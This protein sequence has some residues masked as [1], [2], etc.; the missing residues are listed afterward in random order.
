MWI[1]T[2]GIRSRPRITIGPV[3]SSRSLLIMLHKQFGLPKN[4]GE[5][6]M[7]GAWGLGGCSGSPVEV[8]VTWTGFSNTAAATTA[9]HTSPTSHTRL[10]TPMTST[11]SKINFSYVALGLDATVGVTAESFTRV[12]CVVPRDASRTLLLGTPTDPRHGHCVGNRR[13]R[14]QSSSGTRVG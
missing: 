8:R 6:A 7:S 13:E 9:D 1:A 14:I 3:R 5:H 2:R 12:S 4:S 10:A 11:N